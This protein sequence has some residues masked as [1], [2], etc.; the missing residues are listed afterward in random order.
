MLP[1]RIID[2]P[3]KPRFRRYR[4]RSQ[5]GSHPTTTKK[6]PESGPSE[7]RGSIP[8][9]ADS[10]IREFFPKLEER[11][12]EAGRELSPDTGIA[13][14]Q[15][16]VARAVFAAYLESGVEFRSAAELFGRVAV[17]WRPV[18]AT[19]NEAL[20]R[21]RFELIDKEIEGAMS[22]A[23]VIEL[24]GL[25]QMMRDHVDSETNLPTRGARAL[26][27]RLTGLNPEDRP[28]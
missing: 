26:L 9:V 14:A 19:W 15:E 24:A 12:A 23:E 7:S 18:N 17:E 11:I 16:A 6:P 25:T 1:W 28:D 20:N 10:W 2:R 13:G 22:P 27:Q 3:R 21:R 4:P 5:T 8:E